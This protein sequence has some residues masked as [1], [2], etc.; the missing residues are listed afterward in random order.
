MR[1]AA[2]RDAATRFLLCLALGVSCTGAIDPPG[3]GEGGSS[4]AGGSF[5]PSKIKVHDSPITRLNRI[6]YNNTVHDLLGDTTAPATSFPDDP[7]IGLFDNNGLGLTIDGALFGHYEGT[8]ASLIANAMVA[9]TS[10]RARLLT[11]NPT[12]AGCTAQTVKA[13]A[14]RAWRR[15]PTTDEVNALVALSADAVAAGDDAETGLKEAL[16]AI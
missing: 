4:G 5:D 16:K 11:C 8:A 15:P 10:T 7:A 9:G 12:S 14:R 2:G 3:D 13:F 6:E 1:S